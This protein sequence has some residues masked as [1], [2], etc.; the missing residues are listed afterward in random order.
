M[1]HSFSFAQFY[2][3]ADTVVRKIEACMRFVKFEC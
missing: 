3:A 1:L 2:T